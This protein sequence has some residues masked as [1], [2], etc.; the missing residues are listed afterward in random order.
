MRILLILT[1]VLSCGTRMPVHDWLVG[2]D[3][4][5]RIQEVRL[6]AIEIP[7]CKPLNQEDLIS[8]LEVNSFVEIYEYEDVIG[9]SRPDEGVR[10]FLTRALGCETCSDIVRSTSNNIYVIN[11]TYTTGNVSN[12]QIYEVALIVYVTHDVKDVYPVLDI[13]R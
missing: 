10:S 2:V 4:I 8:Q 3:E 7:N 11:D 13:Y 9:C 5:L 12:I 6:D 1:L